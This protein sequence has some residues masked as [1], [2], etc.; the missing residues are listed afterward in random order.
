L[1]FLVGVVRTSG[2]NALLFL[3][4][5]GYEQSKG[6]GITRVDG[7]GAGMGRRL[8]SLALVMDDLQDGRLGQHPDF[9]GAGFD[10]G[11]GLL[12]RIADQAL[13]GAVAEAR[14]QCDLV[15]RLPGV[16]RGD[17]GR[18]IGF[19]LDASP[20]DLDGAED[21]L[22]GK[23]GGATANNPLTALAAAPRQD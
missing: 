16:G 17:L 3:R 7:L 15:W 8:E 21:G 5:C 6:L 23:R 4:W 19:V 9:V 20:L 1:L 2:F 14:R 22:E 12:R 13:A 10:S 18:A 11:H